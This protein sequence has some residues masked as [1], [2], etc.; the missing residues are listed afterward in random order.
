MAVPAS[1][2]RPGPAVRASAYKAAIAPAVTSLVS[3]GYCVVSLDNEGL[4][5]FLDARHAVLEGLSL[6]APASGSRRPADDPIQRLPTRDLLELPPSADGA[7]P[8]GITEPQQAA[9]AQVR[10]IRGSASRNRCCE[11]FGRMRIGAQQSV[12][13]PPR[14]HARARSPYAQASHVLDGVGRSVL[15]AVAH[16]LHR[17]TYTFVA[18]LLDDE[19]LQEGQQ[20]S[21]LLHSIGYKRVA[22]PA[23]AAVA[24]AADEHEDRGVLS[25]VSCEQAGLQVQRADG[26]W[27]DVALRPNQVAVLAGYTLSY[28]T[29]GRVRTCRHRVVGGPGAVGCGLWAVGC[30]L[31]LHRVR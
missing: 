24:A 31:H 18:G 13:S 27:Q 17:P 29:G 11:T 12:L 15:R 25:V 26:S 5:G 3:H 1:A 2:L 7:R 8:P 22:D 16:F 4:G 10:G 20:P 6:A 19:V 30:G 21:S 23:A 14:C 9:A 28:A